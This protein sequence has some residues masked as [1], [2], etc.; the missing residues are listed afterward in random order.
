MT[1]EQLEELGTALDE[2]LRPYLYCCGYT[3]TFG[4]VHTYCR[5]LLSDLNRKSVEPNALASG[6]A[7][8]TLQEFLRDHIWDHTAM[9]RLLQQRLAERLR[10]LSPDP[11]GVLGLFDETS[12]VK[13][14]DQTPGVQRQ[15]C[16]SVGKKENGVV[17]VQLGVAVGRFKTLVDTDLYLPQSWDQDRE[18]CRAAGIP[19]GLAGSSWFR[20]FQPSAHTTAPPATWTTGKDRSKSRSTNEPSSIEPSRRP[21]EYTAIRFARSARSR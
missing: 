16:G 17:T 14:G 5:G 12:T 4:H 13:K 18:R 15:W 6:C 1:E 9:R 10:R 19:G 21:K 20:S 2:F 8:R 3:Q 11:L 7:V